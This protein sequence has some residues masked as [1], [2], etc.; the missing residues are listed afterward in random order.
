MDTGKKLGFLLFALVI[1]IL[2]LLFEKPAQGATVTQLSM[3]TGSAGGIFSEVGI[4]LATCVSRAW[5]EVNIT[6]EI[7]E[8]SVENLRLMN[9]KKMQLSVISPQIAYFARKGIANFKDN[10]VDVSVIIRLLPNTNVWVALEGSGIKSFADL[11]GKKVGV[12]PASGGLGTY[13][14][15]QLAGNGMDYKKDIRPYFMSV[16][17][18][19]DAVKDKAID[20]AILTVGAT[21]IAAA[22][23]K[24]RVISWGENELKGYVEKYP[25]CARYVLPPNIFKGVDYPVLTADNG[26]Q[27]ICRTDM[28]A[29]F[30]YK[31]TKATVENL[32]CIGDT[33]APAKEITREWA[34]SEL[35]N[36]FHPSAI[37]Y[38]REVGLWKK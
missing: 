29:E 8:G 1:L 33:Y 19:T 27:L 18:M 16:A 36:P 13:A 4:P 15:L 24:I 21:H 14:Q 31:L 5:P 20:A 11:R 9:Q 35:A 10:P 23:H 3:G 30:V 25:Y 26:V 2:P 12:G 34:A 38:F 22:T 17:E 6:A 32:K 7:T 37:K 28:D